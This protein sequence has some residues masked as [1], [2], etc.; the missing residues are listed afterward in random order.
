MTEKHPPSSASSQKPEWYG[1]IPM[2]AKSLQTSMMKQFISIKSKVPDA[3]LLF[4]MG[5]FYEIFLEDAKKAAH[6]L[7]LNLTARNKKDPTPVPMAGIPYHAL[8]NYMERLCAMGFKVALAEQEVD[9]NNPKLMTR[10]LTRVVTPGIPW[11][12]DGTDAR[13]SCWIAAICGTR[14]TG[15]AFLDTRT[16]SLRVTEVDNPI[17]AW[18]EIRR[19]G[20]TEVIVDSRLLSNE[21]IHSD[22]QRMPHNIKE[23][24]FFDI[25]HGKMALKKQLNVDDLTGYGADKL[26]SGLGAIGALIS[27]AR[28]MAMLDLKHVN[29]VHVYSVRSQMALD[30]SS[31]RN[32]EILQPLRGTDKK[33]TLLGVIDKTRT[34]MGGRLLRQWLSAPLI[35]IK[36]IKSRHDAVEVLLSSDLREPIRESLRTVGDLERLSAKLACEK[37]N[38]RELLALA[39]SIFSLPMVMDA[40][41]KESVFDGFLPEKLPIAMADE[42]CEY[43]REDPPTS[44]TE[45]GIIREGINKELDEYTELSTNAKAKIVAMEALLREE[46]G[47]S[48][49]KVKYN[50]VFGYFIEVTKVHK[51]KAPETWM[52]K[53]TLVNAERF[54]TPELKE[55]E[56]KVLSSTEKMRSLEHTIYVGLRARLTESVK[57]LQDCAYRVAII[58]VLSTFAEVA[59]QHRYHRPEVNDSMR[60]DI[61]AGRHP[62]LEQMDFDEVFVPNDVCMDQET[63]FLMLTG[64]NMGGKSTVMRQVA[65]IVLLA[66]VGCFVPADKA[67]IG[68]CDKIFVRVGASDDLARGRS[69]FMVEMGETALI[70]NRATSRSLIM[71]DE[72]GRGT[73]TFDGLSIAWAVS[74][75]IHNKLSARTIFATHYH[76]LTTLADQSTHMK[77][78]HVA[79]AQDQ[80]R[81]IF[82]RELRDGSCGQSFGIQCAQLAGMP[83][84][85]I[86]RAGSILKNLEKNDMGVGHINQ[87]SIFDIQAEEEK[88]IEIPAHL[89]ELKDTLTRIDPNELSPFEALKFIFELRQLA[90]KEE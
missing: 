79:V 84:S 50:R 30:E 83:R 44:L 80:Q 59:I 55:F 58:D 42:I 38:P 62:V 61:K 36:R 78:C 45:G 18:E 41:S 19:M 71:L 75:A 56:E 33:H 74:E 89:T 35:D 40:L 20:A 63:N 17:E 86:R 76:E 34:S 57:T 26:R 46:T 49:L 21:V 32:L 37:I 6:A 88:S 9:P 13:G 72:I 4:R 28:D 1:D 81:V 43:L 85:V 67:V 3:L 65:L 12:A 54:I 14:N 24:S 5:D 70:L 64:P 73:S 8:N 2:D 27:Y 22:L 69:T 10:V 29:N 16:G 23:P 66:Q 60:L 48:S 53:Q 7:E 52:R 87:M 15:T 25:R 11:D 90:Q 82:L 39:N 51:D 77:N 47:I 68:L 31:L